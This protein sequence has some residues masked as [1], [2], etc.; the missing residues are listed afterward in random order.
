MKKRILGLDLG[1]N[2]IGWA[3]V[4]ETTNK[5]NKVIDAAIV[6]LGVRVNPLT[7][8]E[9]TNF[10]KGR[11]LSTN[12]DRA[13][14]R[15]AR[16][17]LQ[18]FK[19][20]REDL[21]N[22]LIRE[23]WITKD[24][25]L[26]ED[27][28]NTTFQT[29]KLR[30]KA[31]KEQIALEDLAKVLFMINKKRG[32]KSSRKAVI[33][34]DGVA[35]DGMA[36]AKYL[37]DKQLT[38]GA[39]VLALLKDNKR[40]IPDFYA[41]DLQEEFNRIWKVQQEFY[42]EILT[43]ELYIE[44][45]D[46]NNKQTW[47]ICKEPF[48]LVGIKIPGKPV[49]QKLRKY[50]WRT[51]ALTNKLKLEHLAIVLQEVNSNKKKTSGYL[52]AI[53]DRSKKL[54]INKITVGEYLWKQLVNNP[55]TSLKKQ[56]FYRQDYLDE[57]ER[58]W[59]TQRQFYPQ[60]TSSLKEEIRDT[61]IF[62]Q[63]KLK[64]QKALL[65]FCA[66][67]SWQIDRKD[68]AGNIIINKQ[69]GLPKKQM[70][71][72]R[73]VPKAS[74]LFQEFR[75]W[76]N[77]NN[78]EIRKKEVTQTESFVLDE[79][80]KQ[81]LFDE[82]NFRGA[83]TEKQLLKFFGLSDKEY[84]TNQPIENRKTG[85]KK[86]LEYN[87]TNKK[88]YTVF[89]HIL[90]QEGYG[91]DWKKKSA[92]EIKEELQAV[93]PE[94]GIDANIL[95]FDANLKGN[96]FDKQASYQF[97]HLLYAAEDD[98]SST[99]ADRLLYGNQDVQLRKKLHQKFGIAPAYTKMFSNLRFEDDYGSL[100]ARAIRKILPHLQDGLE[101]SKACE[102]A[103]YNHSFSL[104]K[105]DL[106][107]RIIKEKLELLPKNSLRNPVVEKILNQMVNLINQLIEVYGK[108]D[109]VRIELARELKKT[110]KERAETSTSIVAAT[111]RNEDIKALIL[112]DFGFTATRNDVIRYRLWE[113]L[114]KNGHH[115]IFTNQY[116]P[117]EKIFSKEIDIEHI[118]PKALLFDDSFSN[119][120]LAYKTIN[121]LKDNRTA[122]DFIEQDFASEKENYLGRVEMLYKEK[123][124]SKGK[125][126]KLQMPASKLPED[127]IERDLRNSQYIAKKAKAML[128]EVFENVVSTSGSI[129]DKLRKDWDLINVMKEL[130]LP[131]YRALG[132]THTETRKDMGSGKE[133][134]LVV[135]TDWTKRND[136]RHHAMDALTVAFTTH[137]HIQYINY[138]NARRDEKHKKHSTIFAIEQT[139][140]H[141][142]KDRYGKDRRQFIPP[143]PSFRQEAKNHI[144][145][146]L[147]SFKNKNKVVTTN[148]NITKKKDGTA[149]K[150]QLTPRGQLHKETIYGKSKRELVKP[151]KLNKKFDV[152]KANLIVHYKQK[153][154]VLAHLK[155]YNYKPEM[156]FDSKTLK[157]QPILYKGK[158]LT[159]VRC[160]EEI[161]TIRKDITP[162]LKIAKV[163]DPKIRE[164]LKARLEAYDNNA[165]M[166]FSDLE[167]N[168]IWLNK[169][170]GISIKRVTITGVSNAQA[171]H[172]KK[173]HFGK[174][175]LDAKGKE[176][177]ADYI[178]TGNNHHIAIYKDDNGNLQEK[179]V[180]FFEAVAR[181][182][183][184]LPVIDKAYK[185]SEGWHF[186]FS[187]KQNEMFVFPS[188]GF[189]PNE[190]DLLDVNNT[191][192]IS[193]NLYYVQSLSVVNYGKSVVRDFQFRHHLDSTKK[194]DKELKGQTF[195]HIKS[196]EDGKLKNC[197]KVRLDHIGQIVQIGEY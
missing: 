190:I 1:T 47:A 101:Y 107:K 19:L 44:L 37:Y 7:V 128:W 123:A 85:S 70:A 118:I 27:G 188:N 133:K 112:K 35:I 170:K 152:E 69:T 171:L 162:D 22:I 42:P 169:T 13:A 194:A 60:L 178:S 121:Q 66:F 64:S 10:E 23:N 149:K 95:H 135:I 48:G 56:V 142:V 124:I 151:I 150:I 21:S 104:T 90:E 179:A 115:S 52:G 88:L 76:Q 148:I 181:T 100:S 62:Y 113:E 114:A 127:F 3:L 176:Q 122:L 184:G 109:E 49:E 5:E 82:L 78:L 15:A 86:P 103:G 193:K 196:L 93:L 146:I 163:V 140:T 139:I 96:I 143:M 120:T 117:R 11:P 147:V 51:E 92:K 58:I 14:K 108:P 177:A 87:Q 168:P 136:H 134:Q 36:V 6:K 65:S 97:W 131:K 164:V 111:K 20:R 77:I 182:N 72:Q 18:R 187:M 75:I 165:K 153:E 33:E 138:L 9:K 57:F 59:E 91:F 132:L 158:P 186:L 61:I 105:E 110:A 183:A 137:N 16:R 34:E 159:E 145:E 174:P 197:V 46:K 192:L 81:L 4:E 160:F 74:P 53:S 39:Y 31:A 40:Y 154:M 157:K 30:A 195:F 119:K 167:K 29:L 54:Y 28:K 189:N 116:I 63:R 141:K 71:G 84:T 129:T 99:E 26:N 12:A 83:L 79:D 155:A 185:S 43:K 55:H 17:N 80:S 144:E 126:L 25:P 102:L 68:A 130:N 191:S 2:S 32:Y 106:E 41:S 67:E 94:I 172:H 45:Q 73:V 156:A 38:P 173:D 175:I 180:S 166:A 50:Q 125:Y 89:Q 98:T 161:Y 24:T 8:D